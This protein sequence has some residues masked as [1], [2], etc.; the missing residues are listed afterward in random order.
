MRPVFLDCDTG[1]DDSLAIGYLLASP[2]IQLVGV[3]T[4]NGNIDAV[5]AARNTLDLIALAGRSDV[6]VAIGAPDFYKVKFA[7]GVP[8]IHGHNGIG[9]IEIPRA[10]RD[11]ETSL[12]AAGLLID[13]ANKYGG[14][15]EV[16]SVGPVTNLAHALDRDP[17]LPGKVK[18]L[19]TMGGAALV[20]GNISAVA[21][22]NIGNDPEA[23]AKLLQADWDFTLVPLDVTMNHQLFEEDR[24]ALL[25]APT[26]FA[27]ALG[28]I[29]D[30]YFNFYRGVYGARSCALHDPL[31]AALLVGGV[32]PSKAPI[33]PIL[34]DDTN[35]P[36]RGQTLC[37]MRGQRAGLF[38]HPG[39][40]TRV[41]LETDNPLRPH[42]IE[43]L[44][45]FRLPH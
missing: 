22:A 13:L 17:A 38:D 24:M 31:A 27:R 33:V 11:P 1:I 32:K 8:H 40:K 23:A 9:D 7:G 12:D 35:G 26:A 2:E 15:L 5:Q 34:V 10:A 44:L 45:N 19:V 36:G 21:E 25:A 28:E 6:P 3:G 20:P 41:V 42:L 14:D 30:L 4:C 18:K 43:R 16:V 29:L 37:D 39:L